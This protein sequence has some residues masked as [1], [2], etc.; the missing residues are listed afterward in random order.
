MRADN[1]LGIKLTKRIQI[2]TRYS[3]LNV[4][5]NSTGS[6][7]RRFRI[8]KDISMNRLAKMTGLNPIHIMRIETEQGNNPM[9]ST[10]KKIAEALNISIS[11]ITEFYNLPETNA[12]QIV[13]KVRL[14]L[15]MPKIQFAKLIGVN[16][17]TIRHWEQNFHQP[18]AKYLKIIYNYLDDSNR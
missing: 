13:K 8:S 3:N 17:K 4:I 6:K 7:I 10:L 15:G 1:N 16:V 11:D 12:A 9:P 2:P 18:S 5:G 14:L